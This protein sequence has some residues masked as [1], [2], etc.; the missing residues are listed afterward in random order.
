MEVEFLYAEVSG[1]PSLNVTLPLSTY[2]T[3]IKSLTLSEAYFSHI[4]SV[5]L[6][7]AAS[8]RIPT[9]GVSNK[10]VLFLLFFTE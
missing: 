5:R 7:S 2:K 3:L 4:T 1:D 6:L 8:N 10:S 9:K